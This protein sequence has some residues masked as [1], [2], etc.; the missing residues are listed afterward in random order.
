[1][2]TRTTLILL[3]KKLANARVRFAYYQS[4]FRCRITKARTENLS[5]SDFS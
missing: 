3:R 1:M 5:T 2:Q 4:L